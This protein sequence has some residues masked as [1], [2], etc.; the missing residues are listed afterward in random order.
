M[1]HDYRIFLDL[2]GDSVV[3]TP[4][5]AGLIRGIMFGVAIEV[6]VVLIGT[7]AVIMFS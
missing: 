1:D 6:A 2:R 3:R 5:R 7:V 4:R